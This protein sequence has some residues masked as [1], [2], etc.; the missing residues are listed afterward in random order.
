[1]AVE[2][3]EYW[4]FLSRWQDFRDVVVDHE[5][6]YQ[7]QEHEADLEY[8]L[9]DLQAQVAAYEH[10][11]Q[12]QVENRQVQADHGHQQEERRGTFARGFPGELGDAD[13]PF[14]GLRRHAPLDDAA[15]EF[16]DQRRAF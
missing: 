14:K 8:G 9:F 10:L 13:R 4:R 16:E 3:F 2:R 6:H 12:Q 15:Q 1:M 7:H 11:D 5:N